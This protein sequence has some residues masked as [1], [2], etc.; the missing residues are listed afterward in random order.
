MQKNVTAVARL[1]DNAKEKAAASSVL[2]R[3][4]ILS[5]E[6]LPVT[7]IR[8]ELDEEGNVICWFPLSFYGICQLNLCSKLDYF[9]RGDCSSCC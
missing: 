2:S 3:P 8:E 6:G 7:E 1:S 4:E 5:E 9:S